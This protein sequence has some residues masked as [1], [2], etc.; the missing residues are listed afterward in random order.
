MG[1]RPA[2]TRRQVLAMTAAAAASTP[3]RSGL[4]TAARHPKRILTLVRDA[5]SNSMRAVERV[6]WVAK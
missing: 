3:L 2:P 1:K 6:V 5:A 4:S